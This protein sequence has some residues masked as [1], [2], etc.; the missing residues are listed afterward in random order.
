[1]RSDDLSCGMVFRITD[2]WD[3]SAITRHHVALG[4][5]GDCVIGA[6]GL[7]VWLN[8]ADESANIW[9]GK[10][11]DCVDR[12]ESRQDF[13]ALV[14]GHDG[15]RFAFECSHRGVGVYCNNKLSAQFF[16]SLQVAHMADMKKIKAS[17]GKCD[18]FAR[19]LPVGCTSAQFF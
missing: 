1:M 7:N 11:Y 14:L 18:A 2:D 3:A 16:R 15:T 10:N 8:L 13:G 17:V 9:L 5:R 19:V 4:N 6:F 12:C